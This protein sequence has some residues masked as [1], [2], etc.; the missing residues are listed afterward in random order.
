MS[1]K[2]EF[3]SDEIVTKETIWICA[4]L[5]LTVIKIVNDES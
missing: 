1:G 4:G 2:N 3:H 5:K